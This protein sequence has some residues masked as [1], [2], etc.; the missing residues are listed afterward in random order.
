MSECSLINYGAYT[1]KDFQIVE[2]SSVSVCVQG[3]AHIFSMTAMKHQIWCTY[4]V[5]ILLGI[6]HLVVEL[7]QSKIKI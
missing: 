3:R 2:N 1:Y 7:K 5:K 4:L 6:R